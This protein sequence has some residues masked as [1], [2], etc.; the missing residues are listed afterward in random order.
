MIVAGG[1][2]SYKVKDLLKQKSIAVILG[3]TL[4]LP[5]NEDDPYDRSFTL[6]AELHTAG[7]QFAISSQSASF[8]RRLPEYA[9]VAQAFGLSHD[10]ALKSI[11]L[12]PAQIL[13][14]SRDLGTIEPGKIGN[15]IVTTGDP[16]EIRTEV[17][18]LFIKG[19]PASTDNKHRQLYE[20]Y[21]K[22]P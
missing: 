16:L 12:S 6:P 19:R 22:R 8:V 14:L 9:G 21:R 10:E 15:L 13:G 18:Y 17:R 20:K 3:P 5:E 7:I 4:A 1:T 2:E 11:S